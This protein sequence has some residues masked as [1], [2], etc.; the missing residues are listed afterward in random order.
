MNQEKDINNSNLWSEVPTMSREE[1]MSMKLI[2]DNYADG[3]SFIPKKHRTPPPP[4]F[5]K[6]EGK[7]TSN[8]SRS[9]LL[10]AMLRDNISKERVQ[11]VYK[12]A[13]YSKEDIP[14]GELTEDE[15]LWISLRK[16]CVRMIPLPE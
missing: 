1:L 3:F 12:R 10:R 6:E 7:L 5:W 4:L 11:D 15:H 14:R 16:M 8:P 2:S 9:T 13:L